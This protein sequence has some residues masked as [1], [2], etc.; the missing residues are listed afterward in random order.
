[1][2][3]SI[4][5]VSCLMLFMDPFFCENETIEKDKRA[6]IRIAFLIFTPLLVLRQAPAA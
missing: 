5:S 6:D 1:M 4:E 3:T 2:I